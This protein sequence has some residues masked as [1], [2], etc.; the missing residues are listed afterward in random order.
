MIGP[1]QTSTK[2][3]VDDVTFSRRLREALPARRTDPRTTTASDGQHKHACVARIMRSRDDGTRAVLPACLAGSEMSG[4]RRGLHNS[5]IY[6]FDEAACLTCPGPVDDAVEVTA[7]HRCDFLHG[8]DLRARDVG[9]PLT[10]HGRNDVVLLAQ[11][12]TAQLFS[13]KP[14]TGS[15]LF[16]RDPEGSAPS[17]TPALRRCQGD[18]STRIMLPADTRQIFAN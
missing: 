3:I 1:Q 2:I 15:T 4:L 6:G 12:D 10:E 11:Q 9:A 13:I 18:G 16:R 7:D 14:S 8:L 5:T 17:R